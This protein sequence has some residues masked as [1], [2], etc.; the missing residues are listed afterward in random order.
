MKPK[1]RGPRVSLFLPNVYEAQAVLDYFSRNR[2]HLAP[3]NPPLPSNFYSLEY[4]RQRLDRQFLEFEAGTSVNF[5]VE[6]SE[7]REKVIGAIS[8]TQIVRGPFQACYLGYSIAAECEGKGLMRESLEL[9]ID[10]MFNQKHIHR[11]MANYLPDN[12][13]SGHLLRRLGF[14]ID[15]RSKDYLYIHGA[16]QEHI[17]TSL[18]NHTWIPREE[19]KIIFS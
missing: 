4:W 14:V 8:F 10:Y 2:E 13:K 9:A 15:G 12:S 6:L 5:Y 17:L 3:T 18:T 7:Q 11:I 16:W 19:D 1:L